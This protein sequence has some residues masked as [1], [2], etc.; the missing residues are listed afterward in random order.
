MLPKQARGTFRKHVTK[1]SEQVAT[2]PSRCF[3]RCFKINKAWQNI[4]FLP[5]RFVSTSSENEP[6]I[7]GEMTTGL[8]SGKSALIAAERNSPGS[9]LPGSGPEF[10]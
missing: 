2:P 9:D 1:P 7:E 5:G 3:E 8:E 10:P 6:D 4:D